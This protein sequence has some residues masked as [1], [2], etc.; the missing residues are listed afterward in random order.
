MAKKNKGVNWDKLKSVGEVQ[1]LKMS[2]GA[3][4]NIIR[5]VKV[6]YGWADLCKIAGGQD[7]IHSVAWYVDRHESAAETLSDALEEGAKWREAKLNDSINSVNY[8]DD[9]ASRVARDKLR[10]ALLENKKTGAAEKVG[11][12]IG[13]AIIDAQQRTKGIEKARKVID[14]TPEAVKLEAARS[15]DD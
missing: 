13:Q 3:F 7:V 2:S 4:N 11:Y 5:L 12:G 10:L 8:Q 14:I 1:H 6:G 15:A 9:S